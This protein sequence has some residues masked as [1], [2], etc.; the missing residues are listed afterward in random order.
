MWLYAVLLSLGR[1]LEPFIEL[2]LGD[3]PVQYPITSK[4]N[5]YAILIRKVCCSCGWKQGWGWIPSTPTKHC[6]FIRVWHPHSSVSVVEDMEEMNNLQTLKPGKHKPEDT[7]GQA[8]LF[9][10]P[11]MLHYE[12]F[13]FVSNPIIIFV[14][15]NLL[16][17]SGLDSF[18][19]VSERWNFVTVV[20]CPVI[21][22]R[23][24]CFYLSFT[25]SWIKAFRCVCVKY[26]LYTGHL[27]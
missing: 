17:N 7:P 16:H 20:S 3:I 9:R 2:Q 18:K 15:L 12:P 13:P 27:F 22:P 21:E 14:F 25:L 19:F 6:R 5:C 8:G 11:H 23:W 4:S 10:F 1:P 26:D 24:R